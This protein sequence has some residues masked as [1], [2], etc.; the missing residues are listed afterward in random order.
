MER[1]RVEASKEYDVCI[2]DG[3]IRRVGELSSACGL[4]GI[5]AIIADDITDSLFGESVKKSLCDAGFTVIK[6]VIKNGEQSKCGKELLSIL[7]FLAG[8][9]VSRGDAVVALGGGVVGDLAGFV[10]AVYL[11]GI[12][13]V[14]IPTTLLSAVD[15]SVGGK[16][17]IN[18]DSGKNLAGAFYQPSLVVCDSGII[19][20]LP[21]EIF[22]D[23]MAEVI[24][25]GAIASEELL[26]ILGSDARANIS[27]I[28]AHCVKIKRDV[29][30]SDEFDRG[31]RQLLNFGHT[32]AHAIE[33]C[34]G[35]SISHG[36]AVSVGMVIMSRAAA[37]LGFCEWSIAEEI[38]RLLIK[39]N[40]P[41][42]CDFSAKELFDVAMCDKK[43]AGE[44]ITLVI[45]KKRG[46]CTLE[47][48]PAADMRSFFEAGLEASV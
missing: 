29:V 16:T 5:A 15:S 3:L 13:L 8:H 35:F 32:P 14:Q 18:L 38:S 19:S 23:G 42:K 36:S 40:L 48:V 2:G 4:S 26:G 39:N 1:I 28:T 25:Y 31:T 41:T 11:R 10:A 43:R 34:S 9:G 37:R 22:S 27:E 12:N 17:A 46:L 44:K 20:N 6:Y 24:K 7:N 47:T 33:K 30:C 21:P 45:P